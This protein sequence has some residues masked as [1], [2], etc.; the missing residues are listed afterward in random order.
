MLIA[1]SFTSVLVTATFPSAETYVDITAVA[2]FSADGD[3]STPSLPISV[4]TVQSN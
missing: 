2:V 3:E 4:G 1:A